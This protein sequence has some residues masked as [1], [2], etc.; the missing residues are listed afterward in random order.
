MKPLLILFLCFLGFQTLEAQTY[1]VGKVTDEETGEEMIGANIIVSKDSIFVAGCATDF[2]GN[3]KIEIDS[4]TYDVEFSYT[5]YTKKMITGVVVKP[6]QINKLDVVLAQGVDLN[7]VVVYS[8]PRIERSPPSGQV[9]T[10]EQIRQLPTKSINALA[11]KSAGISIAENGDE[12][13]IKGSR[14]HYTHYYVDG[15]RVRGN[16]HNVQQTLPHKTPPDV[17]ENFNT[18]D[19]AAVAENDF[20]SPL[21]VPLSTFSIDVDRASYS[22]VRRMINQGTH[23]QAAAVRTEEM[24]NYFTYDYPQPTGPHP[25]AVH[26]ELAPCPWNKNHQ[27][28]QV[29]IQGEQL[30]HSEIPASNLVFLIDVSGSMSMPNKLDLLKP[31]FHLLVDRLTAKDQV[32][33]VVYAGAAGLVLPPTSGT[34]KAKILEAINR[35]SAGGSTAGGAGIELAYKTAKEQF[36]EEGNNRVILATD[37]DFNVGI[38]SDGGLEQLI[39]EKREEGIFLSVL[40]FGFGN[41][42][43][44]KMEILADKGNGNYAYIDN[45]LEAKKVFQTELYGMLY[46]IAKDVKLQLEFNPAIVAAYRLIGYENRLLNEENFNDDTKDA[47]ELGAG[48]T[49]TALYELIPISDKTATLDQVDDL[50]FQRPAELIPSDNLLHLKL[51]YKHPKEEKSQLLT[52]TVSSKVNKKLSENLGWASAVAGFSLILRQSKWIGEW[53]YKKVLKLAKRAKGE[54]RFGYRKEFIYLVKRCEG[55]NVISVR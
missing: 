5:G 29:G 31:A 21:D 38:S 7:E 23:P 36:I 2:D 9:I 14:N 18:E 28:L 10:S 24:I 52:Y 20:K 48:H 6:N 17:D 33:I 19:Y 53:D 16:L 25:F 13:R 50:V 42:K 46:T 40:G 51:R 32:S 30:D 45:M 47:G 4:D 3:Y 35:L 11:A 27:L 54:D 12:I 22:N 41:Y 34:D 37:G 39:E 44:N 49:V 15:I 55:L 1:L 26:T 8:L 43:D